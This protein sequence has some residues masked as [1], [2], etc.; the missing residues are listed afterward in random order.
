MRFP[1]AALAAGLLAVA[2]P[3]LA[4]APA[5]PRVREIAYEPGAVYPVA[6]AWRTA[7]QIIFSPRETIRHAAI[8]DSV[9]W[10]VAAEGSVLFLK[11][12]ERH[13]ATNLLVVT[14]R[15]GEARHYAFELQAGEPNA[16]GPVAWQI[17]FRYPG[18]EQTAAAEG[19]AAAARAAETRLIGLELARGALEGPRNLAWSA[20]GDPALQPSEVSDNGRFTVLR[21]PGNQALPAL[22]EVGEDGGERLVPYDVRG[23]FVVIHGVPRGLRLRRGRSVLCLFNEGRD[24]RG[25]AIGTGTASPV[26]ERAP[27]GDRP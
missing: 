10:E 5:D 13:P 11:P 26:V 23:E 15:D 7:T 27:A 3:V 12:R 8:G 14:D 21:F 4:Q 18:D 2:S 6:G 16:R 20:Q 9:A 17:R 22:F 24:G 25:E 19:L 1:A